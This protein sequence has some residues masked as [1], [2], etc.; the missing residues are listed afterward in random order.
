[1]V[2]ADIDHKFSR[3][4]STE[5]TRRRM[6]VRFVLIVVLPL[7][8][9]L[10][11]KLTELLVSDGD[12][13]I[14]YPLAAKVVY[15]GVGVLN[16]ALCILGAYWMA[17]TIYGVLK[18]PDVD[19]ATKYFLPAFVSIDL[20][21]LLQMI[22]LI[23]TAFKLIKMTR[24]AVKSYCALVAVALICELL[25]GGLWLA[26]DPIGRSIAAASGVGSMG[27]A[28]F[29]FLIPFP[30]VYPILTALLLA[31]FNWRVARLKTQIA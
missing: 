27:I 15:R 31:A 11:I 1:M 22:V 21:C 4:R 30:N 5:D 25:E 28:P 29:M 20:V 23:I 19:S 6:P 2:P 3:F 14:A 9:F 17:T 18:R 12:S 26:P 8:V 10:S 7:L 16:I 13:T 24:N